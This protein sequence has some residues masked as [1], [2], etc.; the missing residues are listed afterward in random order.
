MTSDTGR[1]L[2]GLPMKLM[3]LNSR[4]SMSVSGVVTSG[5]TTGWKF[6]WWRSSKIFSSTLCLSSRIEEL[7]P[8]TKYTVNK[9]S[10]RELLVKINILHL[11]HAGLRKMWRFISPGKIIFPEGNAWEKY[12]FLLENKSFI[13][14][15]FVYD[16]EQQDIIQ[17]T[18]ASNSI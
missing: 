9:V 16:A 11:L 15:T 12:D 18:W 17:K 7:A 1:C 14:W 4:A 8:K 5:L 10:C 2:T 6:P 13:S 3:L